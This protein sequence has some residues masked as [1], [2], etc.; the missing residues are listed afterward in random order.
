MGDVVLRAADVS[1]ALVPLVPRVDDEE[2]VLVLAR[3]LVG[4]LAEH[5]DQRRLVG[6]AD[7]V[8]LA[9]RQEGPVRLGVERHLARVEVGAVLLLRQPEG[10]DAALLQKAG[11]L[12]LD[13]LVAAHPDRPEP[14]DRHLPGV[15]VGQAVEAED[16][17]ELAV[18]PGVPAAAFAAVLGRCQAG[19]EE[20]LLLCEL[21]EVL[22]PDSLVVVL[23]D[24]S[25]AL[26]L[27][28]VDRGE[29]QLATGLVRVLADASFRV[30]EHGVLPPEVERCSTSIQSRA[31]RV[32]PSR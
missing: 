7:V 28:E 12:P 5:R 18:A 19:R 29:H 30:E 8:L 13:L 14:E 32:T 11:R 16:L 21:E 26:R 17:V 22:V 15:P 24:L 3:L 10:E 23:F 31:L 27:E 20:L 9:A 4:H 2:D 25:Q 1:D 6:V